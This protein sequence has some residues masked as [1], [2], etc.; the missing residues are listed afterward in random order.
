M[1]GERPG[2]RLADEAHCGH[3]R[4]S[5]RHPSCFSVASIQAIS[6]GPA[7]RFLAATNAF[8]SSVFRFMPIPQALSV[9]TLE[10]SG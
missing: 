4:S 9:A 8:R 2:V 10:R 1:L 3:Q 5:I 7:S 6:T